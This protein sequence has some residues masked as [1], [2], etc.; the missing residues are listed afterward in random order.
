MVALSCFVVL[1]CCTD[2]QTY[3]FHL[4]KHS[5]WIKAALYLN[6]SSSVRAHLKAVQEDMEALQS[7]VG[8]W[9]GPA[10]CSACD[11]GKLLTVSYRRRGSISLAQCLR[12]FKKSYCVGGILTVAGREERGD[13]GGSRG[14]ERRGQGGGGGRGLQSLFLLLE[15]HRSYWTRCYDVT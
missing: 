6:L 1:Q 7:D 12:Q 8:V 4:F 10:T 11:P 14:K 5:M 9:L 13:K 3:P 15:G 2:F